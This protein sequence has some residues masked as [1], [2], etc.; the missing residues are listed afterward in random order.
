MKIK[1]FS[2]SLP[3]A[4]HPSENQDTF[5][6]DKENNSAG[7]FDGIGGIAGG[8]KAATWCAQCFKSRANLKSLEAVFRECHYILKEKGEE[9]FGHQI[10]TTAAMVRIYPRDSE[11]VVVWGSVGDSRVYH[12]SNLGLLQI[13]VDDSVVTQAFEKGWLNQAKA[14]RIRQAEDLK[15]FSKLE[16]DLFQG[17]NIIT[18]AVGLGAMNPRIG[19]FKARKGDLII[20]TSDGVHDNLINKE[21]AQILQKGSPDPAKELVEAAEAVSKGS[22]LRAKP[23]DITAIVVKLE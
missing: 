15:G 21:I 13:S 10:G 12:F 6:I 14:E 20:L 11:S 9:A 8:K 3:C 19:K 22:S 7:V 18:Q 2:A 23:D 4:A 16:K 5:F 1:F 17:R